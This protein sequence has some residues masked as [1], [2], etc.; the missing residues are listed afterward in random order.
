MRVI[1]ERLRTLGPGEIGEVVAGSASGNTDFTYHGDDAKRHAPIGTACSRPATSATSTRTAILYLCD[2]KIDMIISGGVNIYPAAIEA[3]LH[4][5]AGRAPTA[6]CSGSPT[7]SSARPSTRWSQLR[8]GQAAGE[9]RGEGLP[10][11]AD[12]GLPGP[13]TGRVPRRL[14]ARGLG[15]DLQAQAARPVLGRRGTVDLMELVRRL[16]DEDLAILELERGP[17]V[18]RTCKVLILERP[19][20][21]AELRASIGSRL[22]GAPEL[23]LRLQDEDGTLWWA[24]DDAIDLRD[25]VVAD[26]GPPLD[27]D[28]LRAAIAHLFEQR[29]DRTRPLWRIDL[30]PP[31][32][33]RRGALVWRIHHALADGSTVMRIGHSAVWNE[34]ESGARAAAAPSRRGEPALR[35]RAG[36]PHARPRGSAPLAP[37]PVRRRDRLGAVG[38]IR[39]RGPRGPPSGGG[40]DVRSDR[41]RRR[42]D[43]CVRR[44][45]AVAGGDALPRRPGPGE[46]AG[47]LAW[48]G[49]RPGPRAARKP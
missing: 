31:L 1:D 39:E 16:S 21:V 24:R 18:G 7:R 19:V 30:L 41:Q 13:T 14:A 36:A 5:H 10:P 42:A 23:T 26:A 9:D 46:G 25:H 6:R 8:P 29:L 3:E 15:Q 28:A 43:G 34:L 22:E 27:G 2:R 12:R 4:K 17:V 47:Q 38:G 37:I 48:R 20:D 35:R 45:A 11:R 49:A 44:P 40:I 32:D 33:D